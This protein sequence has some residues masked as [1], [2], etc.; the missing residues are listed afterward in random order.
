MARVLTC[1]R[2]GQTHAGAIPSKGST[3][4]VCTRCV[5]SLFV[6]APADASASRSTGPR[7]PSTRKKVTK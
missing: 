7:K 2:C 6:V 1:P 3:S 4:V 5:P